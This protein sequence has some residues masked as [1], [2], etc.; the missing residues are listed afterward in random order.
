MTVWIFLS[1]RADF[2]TRCDLDPAECASAE[3][4]RQSEQNDCDRHEW[5]ACDV[6]EQDEEDGDDGEDCCDVVLHNFSVGLPEVTLS[7]CLEQD[8]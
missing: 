5:R 1:H 8:S 7:V 3:N 2:F 6:S 4:N